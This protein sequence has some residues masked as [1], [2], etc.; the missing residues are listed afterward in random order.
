MIAGVIN[1]IDKAIVMIDDAIF[2]SMKNKIQK[3]NKL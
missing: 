1:P 3:Q 2:E